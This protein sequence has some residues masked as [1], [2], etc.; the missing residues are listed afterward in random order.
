MNAIGRDHNICF[1]TLTVGEGDD[2]AFLVLL[3]PGT[4]VT[5][6]NDVARYSSR[7]HSEQVGAVHPVKFDLI[8]KLRGPHGRRVG[9]VFSQELSLPP[10]R[11]QL[12]NILAETQPTEHAD[13]VRL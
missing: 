10:A 8:R 12:Q 3:E 4:F 9:A 11:T 7:Q 6:A 13:A 1:G 2:G 5:G